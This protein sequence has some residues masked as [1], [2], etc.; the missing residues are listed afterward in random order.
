MLRQLNLVPNAVNLCLVIKV[1]NPGI[2]VFLLFLPTAKNI[3]VHIHVCL[4]ECCIAC[5]FYLVVEGTD[6]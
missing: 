5:L 3:E 4:V 1:Y 2:W 6:V